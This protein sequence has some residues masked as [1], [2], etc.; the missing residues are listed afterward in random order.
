MPIP[1]LLSLSGDDFLL[2]VHRA[3][4]RRSGG[5]FDSFAPG[6]V[7]FRQEAAICK[8]RL[9]IG[10]RADAAHGRAPLYRQQST[11][12]RVNQSTGRVLG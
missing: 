5:A 2:K 6:S 3:D 10:K 9:R 4:G 12:L 8:H 1:T 11:H 7:G